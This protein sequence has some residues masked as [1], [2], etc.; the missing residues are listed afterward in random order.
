MKPVFITLAFVFTLFSAVAQNNLPTI[1]QVSNQSATEDDAE[2]TVALTGITDGD[3]GS[4]TLSLSVTSDNAALFSTLE[5]EKNAA[6][7]SLVYQS[8]PDANGSAEVTISVTD[9]DGTTNM[10]FTI[11]ITPVNDPPT[12]DPHADV[13]VN[14]DADTVKVTLTGLSGGPA[15][16]D[17]GLLFTMY[18]SNSSVSD[19]MY[20]HY[21]T[22][23]SDGILD[24]IVKA[25]SAGV[26]NIQIQVI[27]EL[28]SNNVTINFNLTVIA[29]N[30]APT[31]DPVSDEVIEN[32]G[33]EHTIA[34]TGISEGPGN[35][36]LQ[37]LTFDVSSDNNSLFS[38]LSVDYTENS[39]TGVLRY[40]PA[41]SATG[42]AN[43]TVRLSDNGGTVN[44]GA[45]FVEHT[46]KVT[47]NNTATLIKQLNETE[48]SLYPNPVSDMLNV[49]LP[50]TVTGKIAVDIYSVNGEKVLSNTFNGGSLQVPVG[51]LSSGWYQ[52]KATTG[53][54]VYSG[55]FLVK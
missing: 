26:S 25:D 54:G 42:E 13:T 53:N 8:A 23:D 22:G 5:I 30:D 49:T 27:D 21:K 19:D 3:S 18:S 55:R 16:E 37:T 7:Y 43:V 14:E 33:L 44:G 9:D 2:Q 17:Q 39:T 12:I 10:S 41:S 11:T 50:A 51:T 1:D 48:L 4:Q 52:I 15:D 36:R 35:E 34:L 29:V 46:F 32:D 31:F 6:D 20:M 24:I 38:N 40:T 45:D 47:I 28:Y